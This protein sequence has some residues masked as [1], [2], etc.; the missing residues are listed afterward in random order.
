MD[1]GEERCPPQQ[2]FGSLVVCMVSRGRVVDKV[3]D[4][5]GVHDLAHKHGDVLPCVVCHH[6]A[7]GRNLGSN[8]LFCHALGKLLVRFLSQFQF[9]PSTSFGGEV[10]DG[11]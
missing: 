10:R 5:A 9:F 6:V 7:P 11:R 3:V 1:V 4:A 2:L 8:D